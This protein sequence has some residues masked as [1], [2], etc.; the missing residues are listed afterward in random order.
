MTQEALEHITKAAYYG[1]LA[2]HDVRADPT[3]R[4]AYIRNAEEARMAADKI[5]GDTSLD[6]KAVAAAEAEGVRRAEAFQEQFKHDTTVGY[7]VR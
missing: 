2:Q 4:N 3:N 6:P 1:Y 5:L 7:V